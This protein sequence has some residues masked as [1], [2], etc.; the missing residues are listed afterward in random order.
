MNYINNI[1]VLIL[2]SLI[3]FF[4]DCDV[5]ENI[6]TNLKNCIKLK[7]LYLNSK[8]KHFVR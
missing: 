5:T 1:E 8:N 7:E 6:L 3:I 4:L 2:E